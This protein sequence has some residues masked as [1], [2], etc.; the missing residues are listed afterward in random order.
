MQKVSAV[1]CV[2]FITSFSKAKQCKYRAHTP[3]KELDGPSAESPRLRFPTRAVNRMVVITVG[4]E[5]R[6]KGGRRGVV[7]KYVDTNDSKYS[8]VIRIMIKQCGQMQC[9]LEVRYVCIITSDGL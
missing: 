2:L 9:L 4:E 5:K 8:Y 7:Y 1:S 6:G 3:A